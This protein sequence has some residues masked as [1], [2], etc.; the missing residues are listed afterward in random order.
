PGPPFSP[1]ASISG[2]T[3]WGRPH[4][5]YPPPISNGA[6]QNHGPFPTV[7]LPT[8]LTTANAATM[9]PPGV[10]AEDEPSPP[11]KFAVVAP[12]PEPMLPSAKSVPAAAAAV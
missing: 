2:A 8:A 9:T 1:L 4:P 7:A 12:S 6:A 10:S 5:P 3:A 11:L